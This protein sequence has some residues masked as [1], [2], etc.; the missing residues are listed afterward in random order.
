[1]VISWPKRI[2]DQR[3]LRSQFIHVTDIT[4][5]L[6]DIAGI[7]APE[8]VN[9]IAQ[10]PMNG[11]SF[12]ATFDDAKAPE[13]HTQ[14]YFEMLGNRGMYK[15]GWLAS[16]RLPRVPWKFGPEMLET[17]APGVWDPDQD[18]CELYNLD[19]DY[20]QADDLA[21]KYPEKLAELKTLFWAEAE[22]NHVTPLLASAAMAWGIRPP[23]E[24]MKFTYYPGTENIASGMIPRFYN[25]SYTISADLDVHRNT[26]FVWWCFGTDGVIIANGS[27]LGGFSLYVQGGRLRHTYSFQGLKIDTLV[28]DEPLPTGKV[29]VRYQFTADVPGQMATGGTGRL[30]VNGSQVAEGHIEHTVP[31]RF[32][33]YA[34]MDIGRDNGL[35]VSPNYYYYLRA[36]FPFAGKIEKVDVFLEPAPFVPLTRAAAPRP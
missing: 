10:T 6:L 18:P 36:P 14:Q 12:A 30:F 7:A 32:S 1:M 15:E 11:V 27:F 22:K 17:F 2:R 4:P 8:Q 28:A 26:C 3:G 31:L 21:A 34:G 29:N 19:A 35:P 25:R 24:R 13:R 9:G 23:E 20:A 16:C 33:G 5:T